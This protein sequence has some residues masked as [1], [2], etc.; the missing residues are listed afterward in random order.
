MADVITTLGYFCPLCGKQVPVIS[1]SPRPHPAESFF[2][3]CECGYTRT[4]PLSELQELEIWWEE[5]A[6]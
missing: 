4:V 6:A 2:S 5:K 1:S 3:E